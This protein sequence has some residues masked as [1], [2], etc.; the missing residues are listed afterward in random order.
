MYLMPLPKGMDV[1]NIPKVLK[2][3]N[4]NE[5]VDLKVNYFYALE[6]EN[7]LSNHGK[8]YIRKSTFSDKVDSIDEILSNIGQTENFQNGFKGSSDGKC[9]K[10]EQFP[11][12]VV[13]HLLHRLF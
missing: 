6:P 5:V 13:I 4:Q 12:G 3:P 1:G 2:I 9:V 8:K 11:K 10:M 7:Y